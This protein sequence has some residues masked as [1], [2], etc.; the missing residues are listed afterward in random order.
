MDIV[1]GEILPPLGMMGMYICMGKQNP[2][3]IT[4]E[5]I[6]P[7]KLGVQSNRQ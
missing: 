1:L 3:P 4:M 2:N 6:Y 7:I 5:K